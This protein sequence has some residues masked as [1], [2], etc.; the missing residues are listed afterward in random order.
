MYCLQETKEHIEMI[1]QHM[2]SWCKV[3]IFVIMSH[4]GKGHVE[5]TD[6]NPLY[7]DEDIITPFDGNHCPVLKG[8]PKVFLIQACRGKRMCS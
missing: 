2:G 4:G 1:K 6:G 7:V 5:G 3:F 8:I